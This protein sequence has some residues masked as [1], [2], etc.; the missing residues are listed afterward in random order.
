M[1]AARR[2]RRR[3][4]SSAGVPVLGICYGEQAMVAAARR[5]GRGRASPRVR[6]RRASGRSTNTPLFDG[7]CEKGER[8]AGVDE[9]RRPRHRAAARLPRRRH[10]DR[11]RRSRRSPTRSAGST[12]CSS[13]PRWCTRRRA[14]RCSGIS[15]ARIAG[16]AADWTHGAVPRGRGRAHPRA[17]GQ[18]AVICGLSGGVDSSVAAVLIHEAIGDQ[19][20]CIFVDNGLLREG[21][22]EEV[23]DAVPR[24]LQHPAD[25]TSTPPTLFLDALQA[26]AIP[27]RSARSSAGSSSTCSRRRR[28]RSAARNSWRRARSIPT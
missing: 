11:M 4:S 19:L 9:P 25:R 28:R 17:G 21:E 18:G 2:A 10:L 7:V 22:A 24:P 16:C 8:G 27:R 13:I 15:C 5:Q 20:T 26:S 12:A 3:R 14:R 1:R 23:V 6:P